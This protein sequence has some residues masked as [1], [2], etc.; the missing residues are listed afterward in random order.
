M[1]YHTIPYSLSSESVFQV[2]LAIVGRVSVSWLLDSLIKTT[3]LLNFHNVQRP[4]CIHSTV[5]LPGI[6]SSVQ[7]TLWSLEPLYFYIL[8]SGHI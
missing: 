6:L 5:C 3:H 1:K 7:P 4:F 8:H 2:S